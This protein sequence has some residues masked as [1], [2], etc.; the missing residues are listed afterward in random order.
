MKFLSF[1]KSTSS[2]R[3]LVN[4]LKQKRGSI[5][6]FKDMPYNHGNTINVFGTKSQNK[7]GQNFIYV[8]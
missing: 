5:P 8:T 6:V 7:I 4:S 1:P 2:L 3:G